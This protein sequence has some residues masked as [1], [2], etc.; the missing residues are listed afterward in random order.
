MKNDSKEIISSS[1][2][3]YKN[4]K[5]PILNINDSLTKIKDNNIHSKKSID[6]IKK[7]ITDLRKNLNSIKNEIILSYE[8]STLLCVL[9]SL[10]PEVMPELKPEIGG[11]DFPYVICQFESLPKEDQLKLFPLLPGAIYNIKNFTFKVYMDIVKNFKFVFKLN[12]KEYIIFAKNSILLTENI[13]TIV[14]DNKKSISLGNTINLDKNKIA[15][16]SGISKYYNPPEESGENPEDKSIP[17]NN[18]R[19]NNN[20]KK[21]FPTSNKNAFEIRSDMIQYAKDV[22]LHTNNSEYTDIDKLTNKI[23]ESANKFYAFVENKK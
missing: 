3:D 15:F 18:N 16:L 20:N 23:I 1:F 22:V 8:G 9:F 11:Y 4:D 7:S 14:K 10:K 17:I 21:Q 2:D 13:D 5:I 6:E 12:S 19:H